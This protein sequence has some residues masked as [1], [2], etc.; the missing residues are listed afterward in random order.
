MEQAEP[1]KLTGPDLTVSL[2]PARPPLPVV[3]EELVPEHFWKPQPSELHRQG[4]IATLGSVRDIPEPILN[5]PMT[6]SV[7]TK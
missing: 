1:K 3:D 2:Q 7:R 5:A 4:L 6:I